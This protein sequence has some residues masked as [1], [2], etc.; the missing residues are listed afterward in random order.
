MAKQLNVI[1]KCHNIFL[2]LLKI[3]I[4]QSKMYTL[5]ITIGTLEM[6]KIL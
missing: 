3:R 5:C 2:K 1:F 4:H 6:V